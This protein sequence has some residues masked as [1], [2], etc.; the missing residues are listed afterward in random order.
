M[1]LNIFLEKKCERFK[2]G[3][4][5]R[6][7]TENERLFVFVRKKKNE[8]LFVKQRCNYVARR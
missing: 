4:K 2:K 1:R 3:K 5:R 6:G 7:V 8:R